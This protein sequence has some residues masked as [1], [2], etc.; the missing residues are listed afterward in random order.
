MTFGKRTAERNFLSYFVEGYF[1]GVN[2]G[3][4]RRTGAAIQNE[5]QYSTVPLRTKT[6]RVPLRTNRYW[7]DTILDKTLGHNP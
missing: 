2:W 1:G 7:T 4:L 3:N 6:Y 5:V